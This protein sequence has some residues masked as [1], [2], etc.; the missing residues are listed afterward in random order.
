MA[1]NLNSS[2]IN[3]NYYKKRTGFKMSTKYKKV[4]EKKSLL[5]SWALI[6]DQQLIKL[7]IGGQNY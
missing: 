2:R 5:T 7:I 4:L 1:I 6:Y 3:N